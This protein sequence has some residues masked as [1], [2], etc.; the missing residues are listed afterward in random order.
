M[1][2]SASRAGTREDE[3]Y[4]AP[5]LIGEEAILFPDME[6][7]MTV[8]GSNLAAM[9]R[10]SQERSLAVLLP[11]AAPGEAEGVIGTLVHLKTITPGKGETTAIVSR[12]LW[13]VRVQ[14]VVAAETHLRVRFTRAGTNEESSGDPVLMKRVF[15]QIDEFVR[16]LPGI[17]LEIISFLKTIEVP[18]RLADMCANSPFLT[19]E[20]RRELLWTLDPVERLSKVSKLFDKQLADLKGLGKTGTIADCPTCIELADRAFDG[21]PAEGDRIARE[22]LEHVTHEHA[23]EVLALLAERY[24]PAFVRRRAMK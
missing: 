19:F 2:C 16:I 11:V 12:G 4:E 1:I 14:K 6:V 13:R 21:S 15:A 17:P 5:A 10:A 8:G 18:G 9:T 23:D 20:E 7:T 3:S 24:G 22:F